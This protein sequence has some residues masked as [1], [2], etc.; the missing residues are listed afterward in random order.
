[1]AGSFGVPPGMLKDYF[2]RRLVD[3]YGRDGVAVSTSGVDCDRR[4]GVQSSR[5]LIVTITLNEQSRGVWSSHKYLVRGRLAVR[6][7]DLR[8]PETA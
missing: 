6:R 3:C 2:R 7:P 8:R 5:V 1:M 4:D